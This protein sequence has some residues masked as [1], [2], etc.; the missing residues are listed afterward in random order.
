VTPT[1]R[2]TNAQ[3][4]VRSLERAFAQLDMTRLSGAR[5][6]LDVYGLTG[7][8]DF[9]RELLA[10]NLGAKGVKVA[11]P[12]DKADINIK[13]FINALAVDQDDS[14]FGIPAFTAPL[15]GFPVPEI[16]LLKSV[17]NRGHAELQLFVF[18]ESSG[19]LVERSPRAVGRAK[20]DEYTVL[21]WIGFTLSDLNAGD[22]AGNEEPNDTFFLTP[23]RAG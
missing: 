17:R 3:L 12:P 15:I 5:I 20:Y 11:Y 21:I 6:N 9:A 18:D 10:A 16:A 1:P 13:I 23:G 7:D 2:S 22:A 8:R 19:D 14:L 4:L